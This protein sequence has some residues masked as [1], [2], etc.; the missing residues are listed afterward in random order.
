[1]E[2]N[3]KFFIYGGIFILF[4]LIGFGVSWLIKSNSDATTVENSN[5]IV[6]SPVRPQPE[7]V[8]KIDE[9]PIDTI[10]APQPQQEEAKIIEEKKQQNGNNEFV[11]KPEPPKPVPEVS[12]MSKDEFQ[13]L[14]LNQKDNSL[15]GG[16]NPKVA[17]SVIIRTQGM[18]EGERAP[19]DILAVREKIANGIWTSLRVVA[20]GYDDNSG[21]IN[22]VTIQ[23]IY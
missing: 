15:L 18:N 3:R 1:M 14:L 23:P 4:L 7:G 10:I 6:D 8:E 20:V 17:L 2:S 13:S 12:R 5:P 11:P 9:E 19:G 21:K 16:K 22:S